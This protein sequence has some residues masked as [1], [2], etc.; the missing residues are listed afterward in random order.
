MSGRQTVLFVDEVD[1]WS[2]TQQDSILPAVV[3]RPER[4]RDSAG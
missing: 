4:Q 2:K 3:D 1:R